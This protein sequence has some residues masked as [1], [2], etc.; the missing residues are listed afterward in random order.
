M[1]VLITGATGLIGKALVEKFFSAGVKVNFLTTKKSKIHSIKG[2]SGFYWS[3][4]KKIL[5]LKC[6]DDVDSIVHLAGSRISKLWTISN[7]KD[8]SSSRI[9]STH[10]LFLSLKSNMELYNIKNIVSASAIGIYPSEF[11]K[12]Q[13]EKTK[14]TPNSFME[15]VVVAWEKEIENFSSLNIPVAKIRIGL[16]L[17]FSGGV[18]KALKIPTAL[19]MGTFFGDGSQGQPWIHINDLVEIF[20]KACNDNWDGIFNAVAPN[21]VSQEKLVK[22]LAKALKRPFFLP[23][24]P[25]YLLKIL[26]GEMSH[27]VLDSHWISSQKVKDKGFNFKYEN[28]ELAM[29]DLVKKS[30]P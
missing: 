2:A 14:S 26:I 16:V 8:I 21:P 17:S 7:K 1:R 13:T 6:F 5:D 23:S 11:D 19:G 3:P 10:L 4:A 25:K 15:R 20:F 27:L 24:F 28:I 22:T 30:N 9:D 18:L 29:K 12:V